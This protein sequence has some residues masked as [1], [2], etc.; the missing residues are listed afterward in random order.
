[1]V[2]EGSYSMCQDGE[3]K[4]QGNFN[5]LFECEFRG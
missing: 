1:M 5:D 4:M 3:S 2:S